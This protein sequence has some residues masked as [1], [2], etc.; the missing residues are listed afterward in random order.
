MIYIK[1]VWLLLVLCFKALWS[2]CLLLDR[3]VERLI[4]KLM[5]LLDGGRG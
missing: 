2:W 1:A 4:D 5:F 3:Q